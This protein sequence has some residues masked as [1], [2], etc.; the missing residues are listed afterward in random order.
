[1]QA[2]R[3]DQANEALNCAENDSIRGAGVLVTEY[4]ELRTN[5]D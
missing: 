3:F 4:N 1:M 2:F 5:T